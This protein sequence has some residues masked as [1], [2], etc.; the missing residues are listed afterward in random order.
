MWFCY[1]IKQKLI[2]SEYSKSSN[3]TLDFVVVLSLFFLLKFIEV[4]DVEGS[5]A[6]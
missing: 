4:I 3:F 1:T 6:R 2:L 5:I